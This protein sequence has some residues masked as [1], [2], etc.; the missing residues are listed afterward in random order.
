[1][2]RIL[3]LLLLALSILG[4]ASAQ[5]Q[6][7]AAATD[8]ATVAAGRA[9]PVAEM[10][11]VGGSLPHP[12][13][14][15]ARHPV[16]GCF[17]TELCG[18][19]FYEYDGENLR[20]SAGTNW[21]ADIMADTSTPSVNSQC[22]YLAVTNTGI[23]PAVADTTLSGEISTN[24]LSRA[25]GT[26]ANASTT[27]SV[28]AAPTTAVTGGS[29]TAVFY[30]VSACKQG[31]CT[32][33]SSASSSTSVAATL[34]ATNYV[35]VTFT[36]QAGADSYI[37]IRSNSSSAP[38]GSLAGGST[39][40]STGSVSTNNPA[41]AS[42]SATPTCTW[43]DQSNTVN[44][45]TVPGSNLTNFGKLTLQHTWTATASQSAQAF[46][47]FTAASVGTMCFEGTFNSVSLNTNDTLQLTETVY[48]RA[49]LALRSR[50]LV[51]L[52]EDLF[53][54]RIYHWKSALD[55]VLIH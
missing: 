33:P 32:T 31:I 27:L 44:A 36:G 40:T 52:E 24:G 34:N 49:M 23:T 55:R 37:L 41:C 50:G 43:V 38:S 11:Q 10:G 39:L 51:R 25:Q 6:S 16:P 1:M 7:G 20:T 53:R 46:G 45:Y 21:Q 26:Y 30:F 19:L 29:G 47:V 48:F 14:I 22:N 12:Y 54:P 17:Y 15:E 4:F 18:A 3:R 28:P 42:G 13:H 5:D 35:T 8:M 2:M 9:R